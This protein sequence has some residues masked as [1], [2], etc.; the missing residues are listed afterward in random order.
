MEELIGKK[1]K[2]VRNLTKKE[3][4]A[5]GWYNGT[6]AIELEDGTLLYASQDDEGNG[7]G[8][9]FGKKGDC[10]FRVGCQFRGED[11]GV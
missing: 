5:E 9:M 11:E 6:T 8:A 4:E 1:I 3:I 10:A 7:A 2:N